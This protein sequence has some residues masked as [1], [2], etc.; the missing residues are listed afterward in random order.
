MTYIIG[1]AGT[2]GVGKSTTADILKS[3]LGM[4]EFTLSLPVKSACAA[5][6]GVSLQYFLTLNKTTHLSMPGCTVREFMQRMGDLLIF[7]NPHALITAC[8]TRIAQHKKEHPETVGTIISDLRTEAE[9]QWCRN[10]GG[11]VFHIKSNITPTHPHRRTETPPQVWVGDTIINNTAD[12]D[13]LHQ[14]VLQ[15]ADQ[16]KLL[17][18]PEP[19]LQTA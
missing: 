14:E 2:S 8:G 13:E 3:E 17:T 4:P 19:C 1:I 11:V 15:I 9:C 10:I 7:Q 18:V 16:I 5:A 12:R 6:L